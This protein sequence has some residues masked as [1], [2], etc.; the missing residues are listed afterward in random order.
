MNQ[1][2]IN[3][4]TQSPRLQVRFSDELESEIKSIYEINQDNTQALTEWNEYLNEIINFMSY[5]SIAWD[6]A[7]E[8]L[9]T[10]ENTR[11]VSAFNYNV[12]YSIEIDS[13][14]AYVY[15]FQLDFKLKDFGLKA[16][17][18]L[19][20][21]QNKEN[22]NCNINTM[23]NKKVIRLTESR[24]HKMIQ[25]ST[26]KVLKEYGYVNSKNDEDY[27][28]QPMADDDDLE[29]YCGSKYLK[30]NP[31]TNYIWGYPE[32]VQGWAEQFD[33]LQYEIHQLCGQ[34]RF[35]DDALYKILA[36]IADEVDAAWGDMHTYN[37]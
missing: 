28:Q 9:K 35:E 17:F 5:R 3:E 6:Y 11:F 20:D 32:D 10:S 37:M 33:K 34:Y 15:I 16:P 25:E 4:D 18:D 2:T 1:K 13:D 19:I 27:Q 26:R 29:P 22:L 7:N 31:S 21:N 36:E 23:K 30:V 8:H 12:D 24:L 14:G